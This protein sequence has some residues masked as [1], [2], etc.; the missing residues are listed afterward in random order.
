MVGVAGHPRAQAG[1]GP[2]PATEAP[3][4]HAAAACLGPVHEADTARLLE[5]GGGGEAVVP[6]RV[7]VL[8]HAAVSDARAA[9]FNGRE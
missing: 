4:H 9:P 2:P 6:V 8:P 3:R 1:Q 5:A 7:R